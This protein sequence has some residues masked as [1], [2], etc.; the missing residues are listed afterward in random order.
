MT[1]YTII[2]DEKSKEG[3]GLIAKLKSSA[4]VIGVKRSTRISIQKISA[5]R[6]KVKTE[7]EVKEDNALAM[8]MQKEETGKL[9]SKSAVMKAL[10]AVK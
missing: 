10:K 9:V 5:E 4:G 1:T 6:R 8:L 3:K 7:I 2:I